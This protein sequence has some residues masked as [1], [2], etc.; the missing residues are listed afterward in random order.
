MKSQENFLPPPT[1]IEKAEKEIVPQSPEVE[2]EVEISNEEL[3]QYATAAK[4][5]IEQQ[6]SEIL[7]VAEQRIESSAKSMNVSP[8][9]MGAVRQEQ[10]LDVQLNEIQAEA[11]Q[12]ADEAKLGIGNITTQEADPEATAE[13]MQESIRNTTEHLSKLSDEEAV[14]FIAEF[15]KN[16]PGSLKS[17]EF[18]L[19]RSSGEKIV[20]VDESG[21]LQEMLVTK[22]NA[23]DVLGAIKAKDETLRGKSYELRQEILKRSGGDIATHEA[24]IYAT[25]IPRGN[26]LDSFMANPDNWLPERVVFHREIIDKK[27]KE[28]EALSTRHG[29]PP[30]QS[31]ITTLRGNTA[32]G[33]T[34]AIAGNE[35][36][37]DILDEN[38]EATGAV[39]P[40]TYKVELINLDKVE[41]VETSN[42]SQTHEESSM[43]G[44][45]IQKEIVENIPPQALVI[46][47]R[48]D[49]D[50][51]I[52]EL[53]KIAHQTGVEVEICDIDVPLETSLIRVLGREAGGDSPLVAFL[54]VA[55]GFEGIRKNR[56]ELLRTVNK[57]PQVT[58]Y[59][60]YAMD[61]NGNSVE[62]AR[63]VNGKFEIVEGRKELLKKTLN[64]DTETEINK[65]AGTLIDET[66]IQDILKKTPEKHRPKVQESLDRYKGKTFKEA[67]D[68]H[69]K[70]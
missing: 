1:E 13:L 43:L 30:K 48:M 34:T 37:S 51:N 7:P 67:L 68:L 41:G 55:E 12:L 2:I 36:F 5:Q 42:H 62:T 46:D 38:K 44:K 35:K 16:N 63:K 17:Q 10:G 64:K 40:D 45:L 59:V 28:A 58:D 65:M 53:L 49:K 61:E 66:Y 24:Y 25:D 22:E 70:S 26:D 39:N 20:M 32:S 4:T 9:T 27:L 31:K 54:Q 50:K 52:K 33:K 19:M 6:T 60:L 11:S 8:E 14:L 29:M 18:K 21:N 23:K 56:T 69:A 47:K 3:E 57:D 15:N